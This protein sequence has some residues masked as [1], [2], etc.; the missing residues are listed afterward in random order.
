MNP[1]RRSIEPSSTS[2]SGLSIRIRSDEER[3]I[4]WFTPREYPA[5]PE[6]ATSLVRGN[7]DEIISGVPSR[8]ALSMTIVSNAHDGG[9][10]PSEERHL[11]TGM[12]LL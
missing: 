10:F 1:A 8:L 6:L 7:L 5:F 2:I 12:R 3:A 4:P 11:S 9:F